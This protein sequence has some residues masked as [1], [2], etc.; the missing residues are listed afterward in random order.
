MLNEKMQ[1]QNELQS[2]ITR[3]NNT[4][5]F[6]SAHLKKIAANP[7]L[8][9]VVYKK[10]EPAIWLKSTYIQTAIQAQIQDLKGQRLAALIELDELV[11][12]N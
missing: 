8:C 6:Q 12:G 2:T 1:R 9:E 3:L 10:G 7:V 4:I 5:L 11:F